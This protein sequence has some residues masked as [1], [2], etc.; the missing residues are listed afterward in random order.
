MATNGLQIYINIISSEIILY[1]YRPKNGVCVK[2]TQNALLNMM[3]KEYTICILNMYYGY[4][5]IE[6]NIELEICG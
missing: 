6:K 5:K 3:N 1:A 4:K 2:Y